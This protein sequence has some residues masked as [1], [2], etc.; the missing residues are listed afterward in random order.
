M[1][2]TL[3]VNQQHN[4]I[5]II[6]WMA[7]TG[8]MA[9]IFYLSHQPAEDSNALSRGVTEMIIAFIEGILPD[10]DLDLRGLNY[11]VRKNAHFIAYFILSV[12]TMNAFGRSGVKGRKRILRTMLICVLYAITDEIHQ[13]FIPG[14]AGQVKDVL[15]DSL[16]A[17]TGVVVY[18]AARKILK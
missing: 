12:L 5:K 15:I 8:W 9:V 6:S 4:W 11:Y 2:L 1:K 18:A 3:H 10:T 7:V 14:R 16:G 13:L 17:A